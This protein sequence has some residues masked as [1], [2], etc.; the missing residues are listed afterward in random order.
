MTHGSSRPNEISIPSSARPR[1]YS[2]KRISA[3][4]PADPIAYPFVT[5]FVV[6]PT[7]SSGSVIPR[8][9]SGRSAISAMP[10]ALSVT[11][12]YASSATMRPVIESWAM[13]A[14]PIPYRA[15]PAA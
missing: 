1:P 8:T 2:S 6:L 9:L 3:A 7:A 15:S 12:P 5:A 4:R 14:T 13:T 10:P 11:G